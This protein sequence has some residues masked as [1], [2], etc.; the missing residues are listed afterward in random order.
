MKIKIVTG[1]LLILILSFVLY[2]IKP[3][4][5]IYYSSL[6]VLMLAFPI[7]AGHRVK[8]RFTIK[9]LLIG[10]AASVIILVPYYIFFG[11]NVKTV[12]MY[13]ALFQLL[14]VA[15]PEE[16]FFRG[17]IQ[18]SLGRNL[19]SVLFVSLLFSIAHL[20]KAYFSG[21]WISL[22]SFFPSIVMGWLY[23]K[24]NNIL[25]GTIFHLLANLVYSTTY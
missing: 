24:T 8:L 1:Y 5:T 9:D 16:V 21:E 25:P 23:M 14:V 13:Y 17:F 10:L 7:I 11:G 6:P 4:H 2:S 19:K 3:A 18:D 12:S 20:P 22:L 15:F